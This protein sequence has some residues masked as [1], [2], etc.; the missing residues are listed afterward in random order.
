MKPLHRTILAIGLL[1]GF[2]APLAAHAQPAAVPALP[3]SERRTSYTISGTT[4]ACAVNFALYGDSTD[5]QNWIEV[6]LNGVRYANTDPTFGW[7]VTSPSGALGSIALPV[8]DAIVTFNQ[9][10]TGTVQIVGQ[11][12]P[13]RTSQFAENRGVAA[14]DLNVA[15][16]DLTAQNRETWDR[17][18]TLTGRGLFFPPGNVA[19]TLPSPTSCKGAVLGFDAATGLIPTCLPA[20]GASTSLAPGSTPIS[21][22]TS[23]GVLSDN[24]G[25]LADSKTLPSGLTIPSPTFSGTTTGL[26]AQVN[27]V[28]CTV[29]TSAPNCSITAVAG[30]ITVGTTTITSG[31]TQQLL[32]DNAGTLGEVTK[33]NSSVLVTNGS[34]VPS[35]A[36]TLPSSLSIGTPTI[37]GHPT[38]EG[39][40]S[41][42]AQGSG[43]FVFATSPTLT[44]PVLGAA[45]ATTINKL[46]LTQPATGSTL[47]LA[48]GKTLTANN[49]LTFAA[50]ADGQT[51]TFPSVSDT[52]AALATAQTFTAAQ[53]FSAAVTLSGQINV[54]GTDCTSTCTITQS[55]YFVCLDFSAS[56]QIA[57]LPASPSNGETHLIKDCTGGDQTN[58]Y[59]LSGNGNTIDGASTYT[60]NT[61]TSGKFD[62]VGVTFRT[63]SGGRAAGWFLN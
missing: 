49:T 54:N 55:Q 59:A 5:Y 10:Q 22:S 53:T 52:V 30:G 62:A 6:W 33:A 4:C 61:S 32:F 57:S 41:T 50:G 38:I 51:W 2:L 43:A 15:I 46:T 18:N 24:A 12:R 16:T 44:T 7:V 36:T 9:A 35:W 63:V 29:T 19:G 17:V 25:V 40:T 11:R 39:V 21:P 58:S 28:L 8:T 14:R 20:S 48:D 26:Q 34:G 1:A 45:T 47:T 23:G 60:M 13:R 31:T 3:D 37:T 42:G 56:G 27:G